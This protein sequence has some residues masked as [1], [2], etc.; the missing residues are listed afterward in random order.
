MTI[1]RNK[2]HACECVSAV[3]KKL[4]KHKAVKK[5]KRNSERK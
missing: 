1:K 2:I 4:D 3:N 5:F